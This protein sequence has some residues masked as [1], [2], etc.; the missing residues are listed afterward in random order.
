MRWPWE[1]GTSDSRTGEDPVPA[2]PPVD[3]RAR[4]SAL[5]RGIMDAVQATT[6]SAGQQY[7]H[8][9][10]HYFHV[11]GDRMVP[12]CVRVELTP[13]VVVDIPVITL[14]RLPSYQL[15]ELEVDLSLRL[16]KEEVKSAV[17]SEIRSNTAK[18]V[19]Y[20]VEV[21]PRSSPDGRT[22]DQV[23]LKMKFKATDTPESIERLIE[24][25]NGTI[26]ETP[27][28][29]AIERQLLTFGDAPRAHSHTSSSSAGDQEELTSSSSE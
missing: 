21:C 8:A 12:N 1:W 3:D 26:Q 5:F 10:E 24:K 14:L 25:L 19:S 20:S 23:H 2:A 27:S 6:A 16:R 4:L 18:K 22:N 9:F 15:E 28:D 29:Q 13:G 7:L 17:R 11:E